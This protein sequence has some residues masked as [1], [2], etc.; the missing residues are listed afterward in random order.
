MTHLFKACSIVLTAGIIFSCSTG[1]QK[2]KSLSLD[3]K[4]KNTF[5]NTTMILSG[6]MVL[7]F[8]DFFKGQSEA[9]A[10][11]FDQEMDDQALAELDSKIN[12]LGDATMQK[13]D[14]MMDEMDA[15]FDDLKKSNLPV[16][17]KMFLHDLMQE[18][19][20][21]TEKYELPK[22][23]RPLSQNLSREEIKRY[24]L[25]VTTSADNPEDPII[26]TYMELFEW[27]QKVGEEFNA[28]Q[29]IQN[30]LKSIRK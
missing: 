5:K 16:Y 23:F 14:E 13:L 25:K 22:G 15:A 3:E 12:G 2:V 8:S 29:E 26:K 11:I 7:A 1:E 4:A 6:S 9:F 24:I 10:G 17:K 30:Y 21:I 20:D 19:V 18:G 28:D 27:F